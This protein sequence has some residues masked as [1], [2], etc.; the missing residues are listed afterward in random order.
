MNDNKTLIMKYNI[1]TKGNPIAVKI[2]EEP[3]QIST[4][5]YTVQL[6]QI[7]EQ[8]YNM[9]VLDDKNKELF[10]IE[11]LDELTETSY[12][13]NYNSGLVHFH[14]SRAGKTF[15]FSYHGLGVELIGASRIYDEH[16]YLGKFIFETIQDLIDR[17]RECIEAL[18]TIG[19]AVDVL[20]R[21]EKDIADGTVLH[22]NLLNDIKIGQTLH[23]NLT[24]DIS[25]GTQLDKDLGNKITTGTT[26][27]ND[28]DD[29]ISKANTSKT[30]LENA[31]AT[32]DTKKKEL[33]SSLA[34]AQN[35]IN[36]INARGNGVYT[37][38]S[39]VWVGTEPDLTY[40]VNHGLNSKT[41]IVETVNTDT[42][43]SMPNNFKYIDMNIIEFR[44]TTKQ[45]ITV[46]INANYYSGKDANTVSQEIIDA[47]KG[48]T[49]LKSKI[50]KIDGNINTINT[51][52]D[53]KQAKTDNTLTTTSKSIV[54]AINENKTNITVNSNKIGNTQSAKTN[55]KDNV[56][57]MVNELCDTKASIISLTTTSGTVDLDNNIII[58]TDNSAGNAPIFSL[59]KTFDGLVTLNAS[60]QH[61]T[62]ADNIVNTYILCVLPVGFRPK[63]QLMFPCIVIRNTFPDVENQMLSVYPD[64]RVMLVLK[65]RTSDVVTPPPCEIVRVSFFF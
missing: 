49:S 36:T 16:S 53:T 12:Y 21:L 39:S 25:T 60:F 7:P 41:L 61:K 64:G 10:E 15:I 2:D 19:N 18:L 11:N 47:R 63:V 13:V 42:Q 40:R 6:E 62:K 46:S 26:L 55:S 50:D 23:I 43:E 56:V 1:D 65:G 51:N 8:K 4:L 33:D 37:I 20:R 35:D 59:N 54:G 45:S 24:N 3:K 14:P 57:N 9:V 31:T 58:Q 52:I 29:R 48:E 27:K 44:S 28:L 30:N 32:A 34:N 17:G 5:Y 38:P 22:N